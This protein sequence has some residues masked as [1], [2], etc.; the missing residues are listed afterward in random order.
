MTTPA[1]TADALVFLI[2]AAIEA[3]QL[4]DAVTFLEALVRVD[5]R[6]GLE[7]YDDIQAVIRLRRLGL[8]VTNDIRGAHAD[9]GDGDTVTGHG[10][11][12]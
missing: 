6:R 7:L 11:H 10:G 4:E 9:M 5:P 8:D 12:P 3:R 2:G 1:V